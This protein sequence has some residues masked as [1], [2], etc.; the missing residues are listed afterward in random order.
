MARRIVDRRC[1]GKLIN[2]S[3]PYG[4]LTHLTGQIN[5]VECL[6][7]IG[8]FRCERI[9]IGGVSAPVILAMVGIYFA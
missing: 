5:R 9:D 2:F 1:T 3:S 4:Y 6:E 7:P 8:C